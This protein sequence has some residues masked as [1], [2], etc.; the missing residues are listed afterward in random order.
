MNPELGVQLAQ[1]VPQASGGTP[2]LQ[3]MLLVGGMFVLMWALLIRP[4]QRQQKEHRKMLEE[5]RR[6]DQVVTSGGL[7]GRVTGVTDEVLT[8]E[9]AD[10][11]RVRV[12]RS[13]IASRRAA[14]GE[15]GGAKSTREKSA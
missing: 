15:A 13:S 6:G 2:G 11:V 1:A 9:I 3:L 14:G 7:H 5:I 10:R 8:L 12:S 4:Q